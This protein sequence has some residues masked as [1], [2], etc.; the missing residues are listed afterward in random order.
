MKQKKLFGIGAVLLLLLVG[1][2]PMASS[3]TAM[4]EEK[5]NMGSLGDPV[6]CDLSLNMV[7]EPYLVKED[8]P[9]IIVNEVT[10]EVEE[11]NVFYRLKYSITNSYAYPYEG[12]II[13][14]IVDPE[15][16]DRWLIHWED[17]IDLEPGESTDTITKTLKVKCSDDESEDIEHYFTDRKV[18]TEMGAENG[19]DVN[20]ADNLCIEQSVDFFDTDEGDATANQIIAGIPSRNETKTVIKDG[21]EI[22]YEVISE[23]HEKDNVLAGYRSKGKTLE[24]YI[25]ST[26]FQDLINWYEAQPEYAP[27]DWLNLSGIVERCLDFV[28]DFMDY[29][30]YNFSEGWYNHRFG[31]VKDFARCF[32]P[33]VIDV[34]LAALVAASGVWTIGT[35]ATFAGVV[36]WVTAGF[37]ILH[38]LVNNIPVTSQMIDAFLN[39]LVVEEA[40]AGIMAILIETMAL[41]G[42][43]ALI[44]AKLF[45][46]DIPRLQE[47]AGSSPW[48]QDIR[49]YGRVYYVC[50]G[51][52]VS[53]SC[54][55]GSFERTAPDNGQ[56][57]NHID[58]D[59]N[60][61]TYMLPKICKISVTG[62]HPYHDGKILKNRP[63]LLYYCF[64]G[65]EVHKV[66]LN[67]KWEKARSRNTAGNLNLQEIWLKFLNFLE[68]RPLLKILN[69]SDMV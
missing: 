59:F 5:N 3:E 63:Y 10:G 29:W 33:I 68:N 8:S 42:I 30:W 19:G 48:S 53:L 13:N 37:T 12:K 28:E 38:A 51:E 23:L 54:G 65:G 34:G 47:W 31:W 43:E 36:T 14:R 32:V 69:L 57:N 41:G 56:N 7:K 45:K 18:F 58:Y 64:P 35:T 20:P 6:E 4:N 26:E 46:Y 1:F 24:D 2:T 52:T 62:D 40:L 66:F 39:T 25:S 22:D 61:S 21:F 50:S 49:L 17:T 55:D 60:C 27:T 67:L 15:N 44:L 16:P 9:Q 11:V